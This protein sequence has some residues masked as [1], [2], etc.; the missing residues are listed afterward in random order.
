MHT[1][2]Q[3][4][5]REDK[6]PEIILD[7]NR[8]K[9]GVDTLDQMVE[10]YSTKRKSRRW[11]MVLFYNILD[12]SAVNAFIIWSHVNPQWNA[13]KTHR[14]RLFLKQLGKDLVY[15]HLT[16]RLSIPGLSLMLKTTIHECIEQQHES[17]GDA[18]DD[19]T[20]NNYEEQNNGHGGADNAVR[21]R[22]Q[23]RC[24]LCDRSKDKKSRTTCHR[25]GSF[26]CADHLVA[27]CTGCA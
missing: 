16:S 17:Q 14:R 7:Y 9:G 25:C 26:A 4:S 21:K 6:K 1:D 5:N 13:K 20:Q 23:G 2:A 3:I 15:K 8:S 10:T 24:I 22:K 18:R 19:A 11:P 27:L 12:V